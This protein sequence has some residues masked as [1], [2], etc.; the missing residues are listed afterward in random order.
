MSDLNTGAVATAA[1]ELVGLC[2]A[3]KLHEIQE[4]I[5]EGKSFDISEA[6]KRARQRSLLEIAVETGFHSLVELIAKHETNRPSKDAALVD[7]V[8]S[9]RLDLVE[10]LLASGADIRAVRLADVLL[11]WEPKVISF[12]IDHGTDPLDGRPAL[13]GGVWSESA[14][15]ARAFSQLQTTTSGTRGAIVALHIMLTSNFVIAL[16]IEVAVTLVRAHL[17]PTVMLD[18]KREV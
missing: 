18:P 6:I 8:S 9:R 17:G 11:T 4:W 16:A 5:A 1:K 12:F 2:R 15:C 14:H 7:A 13:R 3:G 10:L